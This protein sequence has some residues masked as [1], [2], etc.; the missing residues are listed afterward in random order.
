MWTKVATQE[1]VVRRKEKN[2]KAAAVLL[3]THTQPIQL[4]FVEG[5]L[6]LC[7]HV[8]AREGGKK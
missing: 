3:E 2:R 8:A 4:Q 6:V 5:N 7:S 1:A